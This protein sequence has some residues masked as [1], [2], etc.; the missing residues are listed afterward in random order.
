[1]ETDNK[2]LEF[3]NKELIH[4]QAG[5]WLVRMENGGLNRDEIDEL[6]GWLNQ[7]EL[8][9][10]ILLD[11]VKVWDRMDVMEG[12]A[13]LLPLDEIPS[14]NRP[15]FRFAVTGVAAFLVCFTLLFYI[16]STQDIINGLPHITY[17]NKT[18]DTYKTEVGDIETVNLSEGTV[19]K[20]NTATRIEV[21]ITDSYRKVHL[22]EGEAYFDVARNE[23]V[24]FVVSLNDTL[25]EALGTAFSVQKLGEYVE[26]TV[27]EGLVQVSRSRNSLSENP[28]LSFEPVLLKAGQMVRVGEPGN[29]EVKDIEPDQIARKLLWQQ[30]MLA[31]NGETLQ[32][33]IDEFSRYTNF[34]LDIADSETAAIRVG[35][36]FRSNDI[37]GLFTS[38]EDNFAISVKQATADSFVL[39]KSR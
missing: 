20:L 25:I 32:E 18:P 17:F 4:E 21:E 22:L 16:A 10:R 36:Y 37:A 19:V 12:L 7:S 28:L 34:K 6:R 11:T 31:F 14:N 5:A 39:Q 3:P 15:G 1:M 13:E 33:V 29:A 26:V 8:H 38:L 27:T 2:I 23:N 24:P 35:G 30:K 9:R